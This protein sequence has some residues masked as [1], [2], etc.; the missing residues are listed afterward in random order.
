MAVELLRDNVSAA[1]CRQVF[2]AVSAK[3]FLH[4][5]WITSLLDDVVKENQIERT[6]LF[7]EC[8]DHLMK[9]GNLKSLMRDCDGYSEFVTS[10][11][12]DVSS[13]LYAG[14]TGPHLATLESILKLGLDLIIMSAREKVLSRLFPP[15][16]CPLLVTLLDIL[17]S[18]G[19]SALPDAANLTVSSASVSQMIALSVTSA[20]SVASTLYNVQS[21]IFSPTATTHLSLLVRIAISSLTYQH[22]NDI[23]YAS[24]RALRNI[25]LSDEA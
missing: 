14:T 4:Q 20:I 11:V 16:S 22:S 7:L 6:T 9:E 25:L 5:S 3:V 15:Q 8:H 2:G 24:F 1:S 12:V 23:S 19:K 18:F 17:A 10:L 21:F 13:V